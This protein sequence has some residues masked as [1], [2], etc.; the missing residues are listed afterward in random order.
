MGKV[1]KKIVRFF[2]KS[3]Y[4]ELKKEWEKQ[5]AEIDKLTTDRNRK[6][7]TIELLKEHIEELETIKKGFEKTIDKMSVELQDK[8][9]QRRKTAAKL[10]GYQK[11]INKLKQQVEF[12]KTNRRAPNLEELKDYQLRRK[13]RRNENGNSDK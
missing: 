8:E 5:N 1:F 10:G 13:T 4:K 12:L 7:N 2:L 3:D 11:E 6:Q 9:T